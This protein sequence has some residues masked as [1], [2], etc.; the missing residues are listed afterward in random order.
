MTTTLAPMCLWCRYLE[1][2]GGYTCA[3]Y[4]DGIPEVIIESRADHRKPHAGDHG[5]RFEPVRDGDDEHAA[6][7]FKRA[8]EGY[9]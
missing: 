3:A 4:P 5:I 6:R 1:P 8:Q 9:G 2:S 7:A